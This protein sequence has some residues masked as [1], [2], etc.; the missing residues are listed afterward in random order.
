MQH[1]SLARLVVNDGGDRVFHTTGPRP[2]LAREMGFIGGKMHLMHAP[3]DGEAGL[4][5]S[6]ASLAAMR[7]KVGP[8]FWLMLDC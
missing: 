1:V 2:D 5:A 8:D 3:C 4:A 7:E 6:I